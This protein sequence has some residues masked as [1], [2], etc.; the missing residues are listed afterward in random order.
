MRIVP[1]SDSVP[2]S[3]NKYLL[4]HEGSVITVRQPLA[5]L[6]PTAAAAGGALLAAIAVS[7]VP[8]GP[9]AAKF[10]VWFLTVFLILRFF[11]SLGSWAV[12]YIVITQHRF[13]LISGLFNRKV[14]A[15]QLDDLKVMVFERSA[16]GRIF[17]YGA[18]RIGPNGPDQLVVDYIPYPEQLYLE[19]HGILYPDDSQQG[20]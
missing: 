2:A 19:V 3:V 20:A 7:V 17:G 13:L 10:I 4:P 12:S 15:S 16:A 6:V 18:F 8:S 11:A 1:H 9:A 14:A 5:I